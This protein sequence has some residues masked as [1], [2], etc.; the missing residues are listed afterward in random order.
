MGGFSWWSCTTRESPVLILPSSCHQGSAWVERQGTGGKR[1]K[2]KRTIQV[3]SCWNL[4]RNSHPK[5]QACMD[6]FNLHCLPQS[7]WA[8][9][10]QKLQ[11]VHYY[12]LRQCTKKLRRLIKSCIHSETKTTV[13]QWS[14]ALLTPRSQRLGKHIINLTPRGHG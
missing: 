5:E 4:Q 8:T 2:V 11:E 3:Q 7:Q 1:W 12:V 6:I 10:P 14:I 13:L 9:S